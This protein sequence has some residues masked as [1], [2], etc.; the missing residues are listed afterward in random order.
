MK[1]KLALM[2]VF[3]RKNKV[4]VLDEPFNGVDIQSNMIIEELIKDLKSL[5]KT[6]LISSHIFSTLRDV[7]D[8]IILLSKG[9]I[10]KVVSRGGY[11]ELEKEMKEKVIGEN[12]KNIELE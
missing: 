9:E 3:L 7:C 6:V 2:G 12:S 8:E 10:V 4:L 1:K 5:G 11:A